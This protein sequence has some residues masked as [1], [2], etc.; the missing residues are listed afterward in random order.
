MPPEKVGN[1]RH[2]LVSDQAGRSNMLARFA[3]FNIEIDPKDERLETLISVVKEK[4]FE[5][6][7]FDS[8]EASFELV[9]S[10]NA[11]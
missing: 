2:Y 6:W 8:A 10:P 3:Q 4:E 9:G 5:G 7:S 11:G 1:E